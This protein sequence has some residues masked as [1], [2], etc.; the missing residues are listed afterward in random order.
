MRWAAFLGLGVL[1]AWPAAAQTMPPAGAERLFFEDFSAGIDHSPDGT[2]RWMTAY[3]FGG[4]QVR[5]MPWNH[6]IQ[7][8]VDP[9]VGGEPFA[10][11]AAPDEQSGKVLAITA[12]PSPSTPCR[13]PIASGLLTSFGSFRFLYGYVEARMAVPQGAGLWPAFWL[14]PADNQ[15]RAELDV[16]ETFGFDDGGYY[17]TGIAQFDHINDQT[18]IPLDQ[19]QRFHRYGADWGPRTITWY[20]DGRPVKTMPTPAAMHTPMYL[21]VNLAVYGGTGWQQA[22]ERRL[23]SPPAPHFPARLLVSGVAV[24]RT[25][26]TISADR[27]PLPAPIPPAPPSAA[28]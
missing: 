28:R 26:A 12:R 17:A 20:L 19:P 11:V 8:Y 5:S 16:M 25:P 7:C 2:R 1:L 22:R 24:Y 6:E 21:L 4:R 10:L 9:S 27:T 15:G 3:P 13:T 18:R 14:V 23:A